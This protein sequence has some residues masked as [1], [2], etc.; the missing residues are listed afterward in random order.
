M[1]P[2]SITQH[3]NR[4]ALNSFTQEKCRRSVSFDSN[5][6]C[7]DTLH[8]NDYTDEEL[9][10]T[11]F[12]PREYKALRAENKLTVALME[13][14]T[15]FEEELAF[16]SKGLEGMTN[17]ERGRKFELRFRCGRAIFDEQDRQKR[18]GMDD[19]V[20]LAQIYG[21]YTF[22]SKMEAFLMAASDE[23]EENAWASSSAI[24][25]DESRQES[26]SSKSSNNLRNRCL[27][28]VSGFR[29]LLV[30]GSTSTTV[31]RRI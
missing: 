14:G 31:E 28:A 18:L 30:H 19:P 12:T 23:N 1:L 29:H 9:S 6:A 5:V 15:D 20:S 25:K 27:G 21:K 2:N 13:S 22:S 26:S 11:W 3:Q 17:I 4:N 10:N 7:V 24:T 16:C 8:L